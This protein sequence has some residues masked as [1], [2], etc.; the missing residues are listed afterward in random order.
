MI[1]F[2]TLTVTGFLSF[3]DPVKL[4]LRGRGAVSVRGENRDHG[5]SNGAG[6]TA[7]FEALHWGLYGT[8][9]RKGKARDVIHVL[10]DQCKVGV[11]LEV[12]GQKVAIERM[13]GETASVLLYVDGVNQSG[14]SMRTTQA[15]IDKLVM[16]SS[17]FQNTVMFGRSISRFMRA[18]DEDRKVMVLG[19]LDLHFQPPHKLTR[20]LVK[21][22]RHGL[23]ILET[24][25]EEKVQGLQ[26]VEEEE[27]QEEEEDQRY[28]VACV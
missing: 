13:R 26:V 4:S 11:I 24:R 15:R 12:D 9:L 1:V 14:S 18:T 3:L 16:P 6:K 22:A 21:Q 20:N 28:E 10:A 2:E 5:G 7:L 8:P 19:M 23:D 17:V 25:R 27:R